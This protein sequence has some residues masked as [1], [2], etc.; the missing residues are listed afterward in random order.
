[1]KKAGYIVSALGV[2]VIIFSIVCFISA[3]SL[4]NEIER[5][6]GIM[7]G[8]MDAG[9]LLDLALESG[10]DEGDFRVFAYQARV[11]LLVGGLTLLAVGVALIFAG[12]KNASGG[13]GQQYIPVYGGYDEYDDATVAVA[14]NADTASVTCPACGTACSLDAAFCRNCGTALSA[15]EMSAKICPACGAE[16][17][18]DANFCRECGQKLEEDTGSDTPPVSAKTGWEAFRPESE[19]VRP[20]KA[21]DSPDA[22][23]TAGTYPVNVPDV[24]P[25]GTEAETVRMD[26]LETASVFRKSDSFG[27]APGDEKPADDNPFLRK[28]GDL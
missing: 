28:A 22:A 15:P 10:F 23:E 11:W 24:V 6:M 26:T 19:P 7:S 20:D 13:Y 16:N 27:A 18:A 12:R 3:G 1:M 14:H 9:D 21:G 4:L 25:A 5:Y 2:A 17:D 8:Y